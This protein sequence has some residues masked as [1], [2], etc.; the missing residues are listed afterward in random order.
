MD[1]AEMHELKGEIAALKGW[2]TRGQQNMLDSLLALNNEIQRLRLQVEDLEEKLE[3]REI[4]RNL[5]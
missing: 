2:I 1:N 5:C 4:P 3:R